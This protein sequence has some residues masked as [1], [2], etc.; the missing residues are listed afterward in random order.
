VDNSEKETAAGNREGG[1]VMVSS[2]CIVK[3]AIIY[4][5][6]GW[7]GVAA[8]ERGICRVV[9]PKEDKMAIAREF[10]VIATAGD[11]RKKSTHPQSLV[12]TAG[13]RGVRPAEKGGEQGIDRKLAKAVKLLKKY[14][15]GERV[16]FDL[17]LDMDYY[18]TFQQRVWKAT[19][20]VPYGETRSYAWIAMRA[21]NPKAARAV[22]Q[23]M[24]ANPIPIIVP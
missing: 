18:K 15:A 2:D 24:A 4:T 11:E 9:L 10:A 17:P 12:R 21:R 1:E 8:S 13:G 3:K 19:S 7:V 23:A 14:F 16:S 20:E 6:L 5:P 22:G